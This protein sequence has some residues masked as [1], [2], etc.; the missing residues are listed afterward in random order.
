MGVFVQ[1]RL[2]TNFAIS[3]DADFKLFAKRREK[4]K[5]LALKRHLSS[6]I[7]LQYAKKESKRIT[8]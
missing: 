6:T 8:K 1:M 5:D 2:S 7:L 4:L 3:T